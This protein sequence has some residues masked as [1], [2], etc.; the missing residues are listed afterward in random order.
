[1]SDPSS[2]EA[3]GPT[4]KLLIATVL[5]ALLLSQLV[6]NALGLWHPDGDLVPYIEDHRD[7]WWAWHMYSGMVFV[8]TA[9]AYAGLMWWLVPNRGRLLAVVGGLV[10]AVGVASFGA[11]LIAEASTHW[12]V[13]STSLSDAQ[14]HELLTYVDDES[15]HLVLPILIGLVL[16]VVGPIIS[17]G[18]LWRA[19]TVRR[20]VLALFL[21]GSVVGSIF[22]PAGLLATVAYAAMCWTVWR[23]LDVPTTQPAP[24]LVEV[25]AP[26]A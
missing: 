10:T 16:T 26:A 25:A 17:A 2:P 6:G 5:G 9:G 24:P 20:W 21:V 3:T 19:R 8:T 11:G 22:G 23:G 18:G 14:A 15:G 1:M 4:N 13:T 7:S 12:Y